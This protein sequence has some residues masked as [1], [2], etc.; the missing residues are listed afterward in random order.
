[1][2]NKIKNLDWTKI[3]WTILKIFFFIVINGGG[4][5]L[6]IMSNVEIGSVQWKGENVSISYFSF[7]ETG[8]KIFM[9]LLATL[10]VVA[11]YLYL[12]FLYNIYREDKKE[13]RTIERENKNIE[14][15]LGVK[16]KDKEN[17]QQ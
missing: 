16:V 6:L 4:I 14:K 2:F 7:L 5:S 12:K 13:K 15:Y 9:W 8:W 1:M 3:G 10:G 11:S 17:E